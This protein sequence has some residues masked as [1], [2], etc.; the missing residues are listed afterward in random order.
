M[1]TDHSAS[2]RVGAYRRALLRRN[3]PAG[4]AGRGWSPIV[5]GGLRNADRLLGSEA[6]FSPERV[7]RQ[8]E[9]WGRRTA[10][11]LE[12]IRAIGGRH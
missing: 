11:S 4:G 3:P 12:I 7:L 2:G 6:V 8:E 9:A 5:S 10:A 1:A